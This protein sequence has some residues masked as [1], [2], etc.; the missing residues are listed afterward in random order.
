[1]H[2]FSATKG[3][4]GTRVPPC[5]LAWT[6]PSA[7]VLEIVDLDGRMGRFPHQLSGDEQQHVAVAY[8]LA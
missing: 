6:L 1:M 7:E 8:A 3:G 4:Q 2:L 5:L